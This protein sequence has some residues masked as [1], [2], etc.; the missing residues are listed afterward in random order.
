MSAYKIERLVI[1]HRTKPM[2]TITDETGKRIF[3][4]RHVDGIGTVMLSWPSKRE[5]QRIIDFINEVGLDAVKRRLNH[6]T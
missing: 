6:E 3:E 1:S 5:C 2:W 4:K